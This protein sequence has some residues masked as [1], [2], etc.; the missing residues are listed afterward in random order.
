VFFDR[1]ET[2]TFRFPFGA[3]INIF[4]GKGQEKKE[5]GRVQGRL[6]RDGFGQN[7]ALYLLSNSQSAIRNPQ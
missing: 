2:R 4:A 1:F 7:L 3:E 6:R 5:G